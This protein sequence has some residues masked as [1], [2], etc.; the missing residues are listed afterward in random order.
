MRAK[1]PG[2]VDFTAFGLLGGWGVFCVKSSFLAKTGEMPLFFAWAVIG[3]DFAT[4]AS[5]PPNGH[6]RLSMLFS[7]TA[8]FAGD[9]GAVVTVFV[10]CTGAA[11]SS[12]PKGH[13]LLKKPC[14]S[15]GA[16]WV[17]L[18]EL[19]ADAVAVEAVETGADLRSSR[20]SFTSVLEI[21][22]AGIPLAVGLEPCFGNCIC[23]CV[24]RGACFSRFRFCS[25][26]GLSFGDSGWEGR[27][28]FSEPKGQS[29]SKKPL[30]CRSWLL[31][32]SGLSA[33]AGA[34]E[35]LRT[36]TTMDTASLGFGFI[37]NGRE[38]G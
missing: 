25:G 12:L 28:S 32:V 11:G 13:S 34:P 15:G 17:F 4:A 9:F 37:K 20:G 18:W 8:G 19:D 14:F 7:A 5:S 35:R 10:G 23:F 21:P 31:G 16:T 29:F 3:A 1:N 27:P 26:F 6:K 33:E 30:L 38:E 36:A 2:L 24:C 22:D